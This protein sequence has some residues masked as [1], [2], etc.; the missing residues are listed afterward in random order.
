MLDPTRMADV[1]RRGG[2]VATAVDS[3]KSLD[4]RRRKLQGELDGLRASRNQGNEKM[5]EL[6]K[7]SAEFVAARDEFKQLATRI[8]EGEAQLATLEADCDAQRFIIPN[9][10]HSTVPVGA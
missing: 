6:D 9:A 1:L 4:E 2:D 8:K 5:K 10:P 7:K 3:W